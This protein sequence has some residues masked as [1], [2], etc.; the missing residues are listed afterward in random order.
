MAGTTG[1]TTSTPGLERLVGAVAGVLA[2]A[3]ERG[4]DGVGDASVPE[5]LCPVLAAALADPALLPERVAGDRPRSGFGKHLLHSSPEFSVFATVTAPGN[6]LP[7]HDHGSWG[8]VGVYRGLEEEIRYEPSSQLLPGE[9]M[10]IEV[11][12]VVHRPGDVMAVRPPPA[13]IHA[14]A[15]AGTEWSVCVHLFAEDPLV[16]GFNLYLPP[17]YTAE[18]TGPLEYD[19]RPGEH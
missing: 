6:A 11:G 9:P 16:Q 7:V 19:S 5:A 3:D 4:G 18:G 10:L 8:V 15:N 13:D 17:A 14:V 2:S 12:R 1:S